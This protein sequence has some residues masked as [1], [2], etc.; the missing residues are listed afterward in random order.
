MGGG[1]LG[2]GIRTATIPWEL[3]Y[4]RQLDTRLVPLV[5]TLIANVAVWETPLDED[6][7]NPPPC[8]DLLDLV[9]VNV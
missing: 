1:V 3:G 5:R 9:P 2:R 8:G 7:C 6:G 4:T